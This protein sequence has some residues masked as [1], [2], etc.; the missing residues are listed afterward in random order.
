MSLGDI[1]VDLRLMTAKFS[2]GINK[3]NGN[4]NDLKRSTDM[5]KRAVG[6]LAA[7]L[8]IREVAQ[9][10]SR[11]VEAGAALD[12]VSDRLGVTTDWLTEMT[13][14]A[15]QF[16]VQND[17]LIDG[18]KEL[19]LRTDEF[20]ATGV[21]P[22]E[23]AFTRL[24]LSQKDLNAVSHDTAELFDLVA[25]RLR[26]VEN[27]AA[28]QRLVDE[29]FGGTGGEQMA[30]MA[31][32]TA[33]EIGALRE[34]AQRLG[35]TLSEVDT[36]RLL[37]AQKAINRA[38]ASFDGMSRS[39]VADLAPTIVSV[40]DTI[41]DEFVEVRD[42]VSDPAFEQSAAALAGALT[43]GFKES[44][45]V[46]KNTGKELRALGLIEPADEASARINEINEDLQALRA[47]AERNIF[48]RDMFSTPG[49]GPGLWMTDELKEQIRLLE[50]EKQLILENA[51]VQAD[52]EN[53]NAGDSGSPDAGGND[54]G[55]GGGGIS[56]TQAEAE[57]IQK[58]VEALQLQA[59]TLRMTTTEA[60]LYELANAG[61]TAGELKAAR[62][63][64]EAK[65]AYE[66]EQDAIEAN[67][68]SR[69]IAAEIVQEYEQATKDARGLIIDYGTSAQQA[70]ARQDEY[71]AAVE[72]MTNKHLPELT[73]ALGDEAKA[74]AVIERAAKA[75]TEATEK[76][77]QV[78]QDMGYAFSSAFENAII[79]GEKLSEV[80]V[81]LGQDI[82]RVILRNAVTAP[83]G[84]MIGGWA[85]NVGAGMFGGGAGAGGATTNVGNLNAAFN[86]K[87]NVFEHG[88][89]RA[90]ADG[91]VVH[92]ATMF[93]MARGVGVMGEA[94]PEAI[95][96]LS[97]GP[98]GKL[99][100]AAPGGGGVTIQVIDQ[101]SRGE[102]VE[103]QESRG[104]DG[105][106]MIRMVIRD[107]VRT[108]INDGSF[109]RAMGNS[110]GIKRR[111]F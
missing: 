25:E 94:G 36:R 93:P 92:G 22:A 19:S 26:N 101:R 35:V 51:G 39:L 88:E 67:T 81:G 29:I 70:S 20:V 66:A 65:D 107:E 24:G 12:Q 80:L 56:R 89:I 28:R 95:M 42:I 98:G 111:S 76:T 108:G 87:G 49:L 103:T 27:V 82:Q 74:R 61:A 41:V 102:A 91:G 86:A 44:L 37:E 30:E 85:A 106:R 33:T 4:L 2:Q 16:G 75:Q 47:E 104:P 23:E 1:Q 105:Q 7:A 63:A 21:G 68:E 83:L 109:D 45:R 50:A 110:Y 8:A 5:A 78:A 100:V 34:E 48:Q 38:K 59:E 53:Q 40:T 13:Y 77:N 11:T 31:S 57:A 55:A 43:T 79:E 46:I 73:L 18:I 99:G 15:S 9:F 71:N 96:P 72:E 17:A 69:R 3:A 14:A 52:L 62:A 54:G 90:F 60:K 32:A 97:R 58:K 84:N 6:G 64:L 10:V